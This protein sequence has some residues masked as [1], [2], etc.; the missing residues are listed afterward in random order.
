MVRKGLLV[1][2]DD[3]TIHRIVELGQLRIPR[4]SDCTF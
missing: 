2:S 1:V 4:N 3:A